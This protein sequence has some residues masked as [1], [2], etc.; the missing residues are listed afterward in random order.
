MRVERLQHDLSKGLYMIYN[1]VSCLYVVSIGKPRIN[2]KCELL[3]DNILFTSKSI[4]ECLDYW[5]KRGSK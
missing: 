5:N 4:N 3:T 1:E 2:H